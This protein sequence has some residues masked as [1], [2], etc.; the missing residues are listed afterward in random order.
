MAKKKKA[1]GRPKKNLTEKQREKEA[2]KYQR[3]YYDENKEKISEQRSE[4]WKKNKRLRESQAKR[5]REARSIKRAE[6]HAEKMEE[7]REASEA[8]WEEHGLQD[9]RLLRVGNKNILIYST[10][11]LAKHVY[12][13]PQTIR[14]WI[15]RRV[16]PG[17]TVVNNAGWCWFDKPFMNC[18]FQAMSRTMLLDGRTPEHILRQL[19]REELDRA[20]KGVVWSPFN[21]KEGAKKAKKK[22]RKK[23]KRSTRR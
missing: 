22:V 1:R 5:D 15:S 10:G 2:K 21:G 16:I 23:A 14:R 11:H 7:L 4:R 8:Y 13:S 18:V 3:S 19:I 9:P 12:R 6:K 20:G 17:A